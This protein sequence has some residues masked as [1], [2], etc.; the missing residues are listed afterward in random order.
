MLSMDEQDTFFSNIR[1]GIFVSSV[2]KRIKSKP[3]PGHY[4]AHYELFYLRQGTRYYVINGE[5]FTV[6]AGDVVLIKP[7]VLHSTYGAEY[8]RF[9]CNFSDKWLSDCFSAQVTEKLLSCFE[10]KLFP[11]ALLAKYD[12]GSLTSELETQYNENPDE[13]YPCLAKLLLALGK[14][15]PAPGSGFDESAVISRIF[16]YISGNYAQD[17]GLDSLSEKLHV[18][19]YYLCHLFKKQTNQTINN[20]LTDTRIQH[21]SDDLKH[22]NKS[23][24]EIAV[25]NGFNS[26]THFINTFKKALHVTP[27]AYRKRGRT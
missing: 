16:E 10:H 27:L 9:L 11:R 23:I 18:N 20:Y 25:S 5:T 1:G 4:H 14:V 15:D 3:W 7:H 22:T 2:V 24:T 6:N 21:A 26:A 8:S 13:V 17:I 12:I 19:K